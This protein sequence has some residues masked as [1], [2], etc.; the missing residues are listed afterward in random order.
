MPAA[1]KPRAAAKPALSPDALI[2]TSKA[3]RI[4]LIEKR[5]PRRK[6]RPVPGSRSAM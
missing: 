2:A 5:P 1:R 6:S 4:R 3:G